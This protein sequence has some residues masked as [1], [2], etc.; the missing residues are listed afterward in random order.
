MSQGDGHLCRPRSPRRPSDRDE[1]F[2]ATDAGTARFRG[3]PRTV[4]ARRAVDDVGGD[5]A[6]CGEE[7]VWVRGGLDH[8]GHAAFGQPVLA[9]GELCRVEH[10]DDHAAGVLDESDESRREEGADVVDQQDVEGFPHEIV[11]AHRR[12]PHPGSAMVGQKA[13]QRIGPTA[14][15]HGDRQLRLIQAHRSIPPSSSDSRR[16]SSSVCSGGDAPVDRTTWIADVSIADA[17]SSA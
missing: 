6:D 1:P 16:T 17:S 10:A 5:S 14:G 4:R 3:R 8:V 13:M 2:L 9:I 15:G 11:R 12:E 7:L